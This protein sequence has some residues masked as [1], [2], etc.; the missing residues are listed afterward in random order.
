VRI[1]FLTHRLPYAANRGDRIRALHLLRFLAQHARVDVV[2]LVEDEEEAAHAGDLRDIAAS[3]RVART[4][5]LRGYARAAAALPT[6]RTVTH[7]L[8]DSPDL[9]AA[10]A[11]ACAAHRPDIVLAFCSGMARVALAP[12]LN[13]IP[14]ILDMVDVDSEKWKSLGVTARWPARWIYAREGRCLAAFEAAAARRSRAVLVVNERERAALLALAPD[15]PVHV[16]PNGIALEEFAPPGGPA[17]EPR[18]VFCG[19]MSYAPNEEAAL[20]LADEVWPLVRAQVPAAR[21]SLVGSSPPSAMQRLP[22]ADPSIEVTGTVADVKPYLWRAAVAAAP[23]RLARGV[24]NKV[25]EAVAAGLPCVVTPAVH[26]G[27]PAEVLPATRLAA[28]PAAFAAAIVDLLARTP[29]ERRDI[30]G[31]AALQPLAWPDRLAPLLAL[32]EPPSSQATN[33]AI[34]SANGVAGR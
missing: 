19:V 7:A 31:R 14:L 20:W 28:T 30:A 10:V 21:L 25:L 32:L 16:V 5:R 26:E 23:L 24:Q 6:S 18:V 9:A 15:A 22:S 4:S 1:L 29:Q 33:R 12:P 34:P 8:L 17:V 27:L 3:V 2:S 13:G 11:E